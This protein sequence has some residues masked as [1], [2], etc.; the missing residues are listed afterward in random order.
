MTPLST[1]HFGVCVL[2]NVYDGCI[3]YDGFDA[4][5][6]VVVRGLFF[7]GLYAVCSII[8]HHHCALAYCCHDDIVCFLAGTTEQEKI[9]NGAVFF[10]I[11]VPSQCVAGDNN[12]HDGL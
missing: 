10:G 2:A 5:V 3:K 4:P 12:Q 8:A 6:S 11:F 1:W 9:A 7:G